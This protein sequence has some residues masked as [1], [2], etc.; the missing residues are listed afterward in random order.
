MQE[1]LNDGRTWLRP[2]FYGPTIVDL[3]ESYVW[4]EKIKGI[5]D[6]LKLNK[7]D[8]D[9]PAHP[10]QRS[11]NWWG[12]LREY[13]INEMLSKKGTV[14]LQSCFVWE[15]FLVIEDAGMKPLSAYQISTRWTI[16][17][18]RVCNNVVGCH[19]LAAE[20]SFHNTWLTSREMPAKESF[21]KNRISLA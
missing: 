10:K 12:F 17:S 18:R 15:T 20:Q 3:I 4:K 1:R 16:D 14:Q 13:W 6:F 9:S 21:L 8:S 19:R 7:T 5:R 2:R 11:K